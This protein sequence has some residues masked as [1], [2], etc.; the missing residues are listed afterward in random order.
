MPL[1][2]ALVV[3][4]GSKSRAAHLLV[5]ADAGVADAEQDVRAR[6]DVAVRWRVALVELDVGGLDREPAAARHRVA[7][8]GGEVEDHLLDLR[9]VGLDRERRQS[10]SWTL[11]CTSSPMI[12]SS[13]GSM[14]PTI[15]LRSSTRGLQH[16]PAAERE[17]LP[18][19]RAALL[20]RVLDL[21]ERLRAPPGR[22][23]SIAA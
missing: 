6:R 17:Q 23:R 19:E 20:G 4:N 13:I 12:R 21:V 3:K 14:P 9:A 1:P 15:A 22:S 2:A 7:R 8:V 16:L 10:A 5:H 11:T 18:R